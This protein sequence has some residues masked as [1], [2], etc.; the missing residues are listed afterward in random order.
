MSD[1]DTSND[2]KRSN[3]TRRQMIA[4]VSGLGLAGLAGCMGDGNDNGSAGEND[5]G[6]AGE[7]DNGNGGNNTP[8]QAT[9]SWSWWNQVAN[10]PFIED[11]NADFEEDHPNI[12]VEY[13][14]IPGSLD[15][16]DQK[17]TAQVAAG[18]EP[19]VMKLGA[20]STYATLARE[21]RLKNLKPLID[22]DDEISTDDYIGDF[23]ETIF[24]PDEDT[25]YALPSGAG[26]IIMYYNTQMY[27]D[28]G[29]DE[30]P[31]TWDELRNALADLKKNG[32]DVPYFLSFSGSAS[33]MFWNF[34]NQKGPGIM[35]DD[36]TECVVANDANVEALEYTINLHDEGLLK[37][38]TEVELQNYSRTFG[39]GNTA[40]T[41]GGPWV[42][43]D[44]KRNNNGDVAG[45]T[46]IPSRTKGGPSGGVYTAKAFGMSQNPSDEK[47]AWELQKFLGHGKGVDYFVRDGGTGLSFL[48]DDEDHPAYDEVPVLRDHAKQLKHAK[49]QYYGAES[50]A[51]INTIVPQLQAAQ[52][53]NKDPR[54][55]LE[56]AQEEINNE[57]LG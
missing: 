26:T 17:I 46:T 25:I 30:P 12:T 16:Y 43:A 8:T 27:S 56:D 18:E 49:L 14:G 5:N 41:M 22:Q 15:Q 47:A 45:S 7:N 35:N 29:W 13:N 42:Y 31:S 36:Y 3:F 33:R 55:A 9:I 54:Q 28:A 38:S 24:Q 52:L 48:A 44:A 23:S 34:A 20:E 40:T 37:Y 1:Q 19:D 57:V 4:G 50:T 51:I 2:R 32:V 6:S 39:A 21:G 53:G 10:Y 11:L